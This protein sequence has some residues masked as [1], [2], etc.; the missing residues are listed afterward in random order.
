M[1]T[2]DY[3][4]IPFVEHGSS[5]EGCDCW[6]LVRLVYKEQLSIELPDLSEQ[7]SNTKDAGIQNIVFAQKPKWRTANKP[8][9]FDVILVRMRGA[10]MHVGLVAGHNQMLH[11]R[12][13]IDATIER[14]NTPVW[15]KRIIGFY[16]Q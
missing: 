11:I 7:Y 2:N 14:F 3:I 13:G 5:H 15:N 8:Q 1:W 6:G 12:A 10:E 4:G 16:R 9:E